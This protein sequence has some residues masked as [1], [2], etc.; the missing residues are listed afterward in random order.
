MTKRFT[1]KFHIKKGD[2]VKVIAGDDKGK[3]GTVTSVLTT[4]NRAIVDGL[5]IVKR[6]VKGNQNQEGGIIEKSASIHISNLALMDSKGQTRRVGRQEVNGK[7]VR[8]LS[9]VNEVVKDSK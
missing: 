8:V 1:T 7:T 9:K 5:N 2:V 4:K 6:H 3:T